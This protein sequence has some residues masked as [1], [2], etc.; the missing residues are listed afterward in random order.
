MSQVY[1]VTPYPSVFSQHHSYSL[2]TSHLHSTINVHDAVQIL[3]NTASVM[4]G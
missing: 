1:I 4:L 3:E 2:P